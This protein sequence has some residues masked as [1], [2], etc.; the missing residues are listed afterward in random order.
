MIV[1]FIGVHCTK[2]AG[3]NGENKGNCEKFYR[4]IFHDDFL[5]HFYFFVCV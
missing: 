2:F 3:M 4:L 5:T 1:F